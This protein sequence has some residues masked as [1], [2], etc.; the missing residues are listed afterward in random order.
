MP[1]NDAKYIK[2]V[3]A[4]N[5]EEEMA[6]LRDLV[7][8]YPYLAMDTEFPGVV[9]RPIGTFK[10]SSD[11]HYQT[12]RCNVDLLKIIQLGVTFADQYGNLPSN[13]CTWQFNFKFNLSD[14]MYA[15]DSIEL[16]TKSGIDFKKHEEYGIDV[17]HFGELLISSGFVLL[18]DVKWISFHSG[19]DFGYLLKVLTCSVM[20]ADES[21]FFELLRTYFPCI[22]DIKYLMKSC[23]NLKGGLQDIADD[24]QVARIGP[25][26]QAGSDSLLTCTT[27]FKMRQMFFEDRIDDQKYLGYLY[28]LKC[29]PN[30][31]SVQALT[32]A[33]NNLSLAISEDNHHKSNGK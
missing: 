12:L 14:D 24:L 4:E 5:L 11:Y 19:Y 27:F 16:L 22:Y 15:Q 25:Q 30:N 18:D 26:H 7:E 20:P 9:A 3:W 33:T 6:Y 10:T 32:T 29:S 28:G 2:E 17:E 8:E 31:T 21:E 23:K 1:V 13:I